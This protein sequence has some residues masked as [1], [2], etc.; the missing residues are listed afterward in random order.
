[1]LKE[2]KTKECQNK[3]SRATMKGVRKR[4]RQ[5]KRCEDEVEKDLNIMEIKAGRRWPETLGNG[6]RRKWKTDCS[7]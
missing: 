5:R 2:C 6:E 4:G 3:I 7:A 1:M